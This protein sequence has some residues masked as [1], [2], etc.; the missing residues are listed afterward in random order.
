MGS[1][2]PGSRRKINSSHLESGGDSSSVEEKLEAL[3]NIGD[4]EVTN[5]LNFLVVILLVMFSFT[6]MFRALAMKRHTA[7]GRRLLDDE[8]M[9]SQDV[10]NGLMIEDD[11][12]HDEN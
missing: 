10:L 8:P 5:M 1:I 12:L 11:F 4:V 6:L 2:V 3:G 9:N 7:D